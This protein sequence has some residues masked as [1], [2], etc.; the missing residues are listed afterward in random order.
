LRSGF[1]TSAAARGKCYQEKKEQLGLS[2]LDNY[3]FRISALR[4]FK[5][6][7]IMI[8]LVVWFNARHEHWHAAL[9]ATA[10]TNWWH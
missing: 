6:S 2:E 4:A 7:V 10:F 1:S 9:W 8:G 5:G 3:R